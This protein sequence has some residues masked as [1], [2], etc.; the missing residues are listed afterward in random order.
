M[1]YPLKT[2]LVYDNDCEKKDEFYQLFYQLLCRNVEQPTSQNIGIPLYP[3]TNINDRITEYN[4][5]ENEKNIFFI[6]ADINLLNNKQ[7]WGDYLKELI[8]RSEL[9][10]TLKVL[11]IAAHK[12]AFNDK[13]LKDFNMIDAEKCFDNNNANFATRIYDF[14]LKSLLNTDRLQIFISHTKKDSDK[15]GLNVAEKFRKKIACETKFTFF[16]DANNIQDGNHF[17]DVIEKNVEK[18]LL[19]ILNSDSYCSRDWCQ[20]EIMVARKCNC[21]YIVVDLIEDKSERIFPYMGNAPCIRYNENWEDVVLLLVKTALLNIFGMTF[22]TY[23]KQERNLNDT[24]VVM[25]VPDLYKV[26]NIDKPNIL[27]SLPPLMYSEK[28]LMEKCFPTKKFLT[29]L[30]IH[31]IDFKLKK[32]A[33]SIAEPSNGAMYKYNKYMLYDLISELARFIL[34]CNGYIIYGGDLRKN[35]ITECFFDLISSYTDNNDSS[36]EE[37]VMTNFL[38]EASSCSMEDKVKYAQNRIELKVVPTVGSTGKSFKEN[39]LTSMRVERNENTDILIAIG[40]KISGYSGKMP[41]ILEEVSLAMDKKIPI[42][43]LSSFGGMTKIIW[44][45]KYGKISEREISCQL[46]K[47][48]KLGD[49]YDNLEEIMKICKRIREYPYFNL[50]IHDESLLHNCLDIYKIVETLI[51]AM[52]EYQINA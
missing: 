11:T 30:D 49:N 14:C 15:H 12:L 50:N 34:I 48:P 51:N 5:D 40:G 27:Y 16:F 43:L 2:F 25:G 23:V 31:K 6:L 33:I 4:T 41:G 22:L 10:S 45:I 26:I 3:I 1:K 46:L 19:L 13:L 35:G 36:K 39:A 42:Y 38:S 17:A 28:Q 20:R 24:E 52:G 32:I 47:C 18:S 44:D 7:I 8:K 29:P 37:F 9:D 21:P